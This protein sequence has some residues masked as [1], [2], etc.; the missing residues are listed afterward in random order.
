[1]SSFLAVL[2][3]DVERREAFARTAA[4]RV[5][6]LAALR[7]G[8]CAAGDATVI[9]AAGERA[10]LSTS[11]DESG[12]AV[13]WGDA[14][15][16]SGA[17]IDAVGLRAACMAGDDS[18]PV[19]D[20]YHGWVAF[21]A[22]GGLA[23]GTDIIGMF[24][25]YWW[26]D[27]SVVLVGSSPELFRLHPCFR[28]RVDLEGMVGI[29]LTMHSVDG[30]TLFEGVRRLAPG[31]LLRADA[32]RGAREV[33]SYRLPVSERYHDMP[34][35]AQVELLHEVLLDAARR[36]APGGVPHALAL[37]GGRDSRLV[38]GLLK[39]QGNE[40]S[41]ATFGERGDMELRCATAV[42]R[43]SRFRHTVLPLEVDAEGKCG[44]LQ[45]TWFHCTTGFGAIANWG[46]PPHMMDLPARIATGYAMDAIIGGTHIAWAWDRA[47]RRMSFESFHA[48]VNAHG[49]A[50]EV[51]GG[52]LGVP[53]A[54]DLVHSVK[55]TIHGVYDSYSDVDSRRA[56]C[57]DIHHR[58]RLHVGN[59]PWN[60]SFATWP[61][62]PAID[63]R[64]L[65]VA[66]GMSLAALAERRAQ[67]AVLTRFYPELAELPL[68]RNSY[69]TTPL[70]PRVR[71][72]M[73]RWVRD[74]LSPFAGSSSRW[75]GHAAEERRFYYRLYDFNGA[76]WR[77]IRRLAEP[78]RARLEGLLDMERLNEYLP[79]PEVNLPMRN[80]I[81]EPSGRKML[82]G[83]VL[84]ARDHI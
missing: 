49:V 40:V 2:D 56:W 69:D 31:H 82:V 37:S 13:L 17:H 3:R 64:V 71:Y 16:G 70:S 81:V 80:G 61:V 1:M 10:P 73:G 47:N 66:G 29:L 58:Q 48:R 15:D 9:W 60:F 59:V 32:E 83:L 45:A 67:D 21:D 42:A 22:R 46:S 26:A 20:G 43:A 24:P 65:E 33:E 7:P 25:V 84:W 27:G 76:G 75:A 62:Q 51:L 63:R 6:P 14:L 23:V 11:S 18:P 38:A 55:E 50:E 39:R 78:H 44:E 8:S 28:P 72:L 77:A 5:A 34:F 41:A 12:F 79:A 36:H 52:L 53:R 4:A 19:F 35:S 68:D 57:F 54:R 74:R 30:H